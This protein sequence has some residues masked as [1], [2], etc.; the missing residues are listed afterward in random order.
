M[1]MKARIFRG[2]CALAVA[3]LVAAGC[4]DSGDGDTSGTAGPTGSTAPAAGDTC[5]PERAGGTVTMGLYAEG[6]GL[7]PIAGS[8]LSSGR[9]GGTE[10]VAFYD[11]L[12]RFNDQTLEWEPQLAESLTHN[13]DY[14]EW[15]LKLRPGVKFGNG[16]PVDA[17]AVK[18]SIERHALPES[19]STA[20]RGLS[21]VQDI[22]VRDDRTLVFTL[23]QSWGAFPLI[24]ATGAG[25]I[26]NPKIIAERGK[27][28]GL[29]PTGAG[30]GPYELVSYKPGEEIVMKAKD[31]YWGGPVCIKELHF[32]AL[33]GSAP[34]YLGL[35]TNA[36]QLAFLQDAAVIDQAKTDKYA[37]LRWVLEGGSELLINNGARDSKPPTTDPRVRKAIALALDPKVMNDREFNGKGIPTTALTSP[38]SVL[39]SGVPG[40][41]INPDEAKKLVQ[42]AK[43][44]G[45]DG[46]IRLICNDTPDRQQAAIAIE[47][48]L[49]GVGMKVT[50]TI[51]DTQRLIGEVITNVNYDLACWGINFTTADAWFSLSTFTSDSPT[52]YAGYKNPDMDRALGGLR[53]AGTLE[54]QRAALGEV[55]KVWND[56]IPSAVWGALETYIA[57][58]PKVHGLKSTAREIVMFD[59]AYLQ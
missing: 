45:W 55:Q 19:K 17:A 13:A 36:V 41:A 34:T 46:N 16:D 54:E 31:D 14:T 30:A 5:T 6:P 56:T 47:T 1:S 10:G 50:K 37:G 51:V 12:V 40:P 18:A 26:A 42:E 24:L 4:G 33:G 8:G 7:D 23:K 15:V 28:F 9:A 44:A 35:T 29:N 22:A 32:R 2:T 48:L 39:A 52:A 25:L 59:D 53:A 58:S 38:D 57:Y 3:A 11:A 49:N 20:K 21:L 43:A 27:D